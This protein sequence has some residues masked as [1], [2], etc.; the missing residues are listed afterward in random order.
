[1]VG[2]VAN[3]APSSRV[4]MV[5]CVDLGDVEFLMTVFDVLLDAHGRS[6]V[7]LFVGEELI[8]TARHKDKLQ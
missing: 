1:M 6:K 3:I 7:F 2:T 4:R 5:G 8:A